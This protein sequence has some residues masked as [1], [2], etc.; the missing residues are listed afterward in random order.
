M[1]DYWPQVIT[2]AA[3]LLG[4]V[5]GGFITWGIQHRTAERERA[6]R[7]RAL[8]VAL[9]AEIDSFLDLMEHRNHVAAVRAIIAANRAGT[10]TLPGRWLTDDERKTSPFPFFDANIASLGLLDVDTLRDLATFHRR[11]AGVRA[12]LIS[13]IDGAFANTPANVVA[14]IMERELALWS[15]A[16]SLG[17]A[18][19]RALREAAS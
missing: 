13:A 2:G 1:A 15:N 8:E 19:A 12:T 14:D 9:A 18:V 6:A 7:K 10:H 5:V 3:G 17:R 4:T 11:I 16:V